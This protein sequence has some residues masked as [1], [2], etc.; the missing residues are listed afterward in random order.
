M[1]SDDDSTG[2]LLRYDNGK[3]D[4]KRS[5][6]GSGHAVVFKRPAGDWAVDSVRMYGSRYGTD[7]PPKENFSIFICDQDFNVIK[8]IDEPYGKLETGDDKWYR[9]DFD[10]VKVPEAFYVC[11]YFNATYTKGFYMNFTNDV[12][13]SHSTSALPW[14]FVYDVGGTFD[15]MIRTHLTKQ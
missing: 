10:P 3:S 4:G 13:K 12:K 2:V 7:I 14:S 1:I 11:I 15:W 5:T 8:E 6:S 9:F